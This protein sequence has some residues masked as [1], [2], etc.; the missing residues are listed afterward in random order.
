VPDTSDN[1]PVVV[2]SSTALDLPEH[3]KQVLDACLRQK[4]VPR[5]QEH[6]PASGSDAAGGAEAVRVSLLLVDEA[7]IYVGV[8]AHR[9][10]YV[11]AGRDVSVTEMEYDRAVERGITRLIF[12]MHDDHPVR[13]SDVETGAGAEKLLFPDGL[14]QLPRLSNQGDK[15]YSLTVLAQGGDEGL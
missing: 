15:A 2:V 11:P 6:L 9:Y 10:G 14:E 12:L 5:M 3:R 8:F 4:T 7:E 13:A 1:R